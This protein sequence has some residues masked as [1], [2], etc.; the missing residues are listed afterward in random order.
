MEATP[1]GLKNVDGWNDTACAPASAAWDASSSMSGSAS[2]PT[3]AITA[4]R[5]ADRAIQRSRMVLRSAR[6]S[7]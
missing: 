6:D 3:M 7:V 5:P 2:Q 1:S 4:K